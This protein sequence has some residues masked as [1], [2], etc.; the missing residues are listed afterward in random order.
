MKRRRAERKEAPAY[1]DVGEVMSNRRE[2]LGMVAKIMAGA[3]ALSPV[4]ALAGG[5]DEP[6]PKPGQA[7]VVSAEL[8]EYMALE[9]D[10]VAVA[11]SR[12]GVVKMPD[13]P[14]SGG[15]LKLPRDP[16]PLGGPPVPDPP[17]CGDPPKVGC[18]PDTPP[19]VDD[20]P[21]LGG[22]QPIPEPPMLDGVMVPPE[23]PK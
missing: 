11:A 22:V 6:V 19:P 17:D 23:E 4:V 15:G 8:K 20:P 9:G 21:P 14:W 12:G 1:P 10:V 18:P 5:P 13:P 2:F 7:P 16:V 3:A